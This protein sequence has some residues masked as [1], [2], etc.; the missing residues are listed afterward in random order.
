MQPGAAGCIDF[1][2]DALNL[3][4][5]AR[6]RVEAGLEHLEVVDHRLR[7]FGEPF[8]RHDGGDAR[9]IDHERGGGDAATDGIDRQVI[10]VIANQIARRIVGR[11][12]DLGQVPGREL[13]RL[14]RADVGATEEAVHL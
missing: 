11:H 12:R 3:D 7:A 8:A 6:E 9:W 13:F 14:K 2:V 1:L 4:L 10:D 5:E